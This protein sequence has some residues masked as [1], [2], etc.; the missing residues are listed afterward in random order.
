MS[1]TV[2]RAR[3]RGFSV[4]L[5]LPLA[6]LAIAVLVMAVLVGWLLLRGGDGGAAA[7]TPNSGP[8]LLNEAQLVRFAA[9]GNEPIYWA[10]PK[11]N[12]SYEV[13]AASGGR[14][15]VRYLPRGV[16][17]GDPRADF[18]VVGTY[19]GQTAFA[20]LKRAAKRDGAISLPIDHHGLVVYSERNAK[21]VYFG[22]PERRL[23]VEV[24]APSQ[25]TPR[26]LV[27]DGKIVPVG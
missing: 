27:L 19:T 4:Q 25:L 2:I 15:F 1:D 7:P 22:Y 8:V 3:A 21:S 20:D 6:A 17:A 10:G 5:L 11:S 9:Q 12:V 23:Q 16:E 18:L 14:T 13:T 26:T 24:Y